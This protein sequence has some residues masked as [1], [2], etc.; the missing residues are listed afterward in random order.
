MGIVFLAGGEIWWAESR[1]LELWGHPLCSAGG[2]SS[3]VLIIQFGPPPSFVKLFDHICFSFLP[4]SS[5]IFSSY[6]VPCLLTMTIYASSWR[7]WRAGCFTC[8]TSSPRTANP[9][10]RAWLRS[11]L[12]RGSRY[13][14]PGSYT[15]GLNGSKTARINKSL[16]WR[17]YAG[18]YYWDLHLCKCQNELGSHQLL[19]HFKTPPEVQIFQMYNFFL[20]RYVKWS[21]WEIMT[22]S[23]QFKF[24][25]CGFI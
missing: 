15:R 19:L 9:C 12:K 22:T 3:P 16:I 7:R 24:T 10:S 25:H 11:T 23:S 13:E 4:V 8:P 6:R 18:V 5:I 1:C 21:F 17:L 20:N 14:T 2:K